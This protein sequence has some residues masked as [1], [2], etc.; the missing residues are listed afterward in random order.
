MVPEDG[1]VHLSERIKREH[2]VYEKGD[3]LLDHHCDAYSKESA[4]GFSTFTYKNISSLSKTLNMNYAE[5]NTD[6]RN[7]G[8]KT[9][10]FYMLR[11]SKSKAILIECGFF[12]DNFL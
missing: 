7:R 5:S 2:N 10:N 8:C 12:S 3:I 11:K 4:N 1:V 9:A 6:I